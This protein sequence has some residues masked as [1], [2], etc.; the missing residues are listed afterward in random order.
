MPWYGWALGGFGIGLAVLAGWF[1]IVI[2]LA[3]KG[4]PG[5]DS[6]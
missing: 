4:D 2:W 6:I 3:H 5:I 1:A